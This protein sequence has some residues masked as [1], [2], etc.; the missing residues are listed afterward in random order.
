M[1]SALLLAFQLPGSRHFHFF[2]HIPY[3]TIEIL[4]PPTDENKLVQTPITQQH[5]YRCG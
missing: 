4:P 3:H 5:H 2:L 1:S